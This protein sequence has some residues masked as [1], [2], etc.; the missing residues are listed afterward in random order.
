MIPDTFWLR[1]MTVSLEQVPNPAYI[2]PDDMACSNLDRAAQVLHLDPSIVAVLRVPKRVVT[3]SIPVRMDNGQIRVF[4]GHR[5]QHSN[6]LGPYKG[7]LRYRD[8]VT[9]REVS[10]LAMLMTWKCALLGIPY[11]GAKGGVAVDPRSLSLGELERLTRRFTSELVRDI[12]PQLDIPAPD[13]GTSAREM[14]WIMDTYSTSVGH[15]VPGVVTGK[16]LSIGGSRGRDMATGMGALITTRE[17]LATANRQLAGTTIAIQGFGKVGRAA[18]ELFARQ[19]A[20]VVAVSDG[21]GGIYDPDGLNIEHLA[22]FVRDGSKVAHFPGA[23]LIPNAGLLTLACDVLVPAAVENQITD[24]NARLIQAKWVVEA[25]NAPTTLEADRILEE[26]GI[27]VLP[28][29]LANA[30][31][32]VVSYL[33]WVQGLSY[34]FWD[35]EKVNHELEKLMV[36]AYARVLQQANH[37]H[38]PLRLAAYTLAVGRVVEAFSVRGLYP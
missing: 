38:I 3:V 17:A 2:C 14:A 21:S 7:G 1:I 26:R 24:K 8:D 29:I 34:L 4:A 31:G 18:A 37:L 13:V 25:A 11:G 15:A 5:V 19:G 16:P 30:G 27:I 32:V 6:V 9:L 20:R 33:E 36:S 28:D 12:G 22:D 10:A 35:E 23:K